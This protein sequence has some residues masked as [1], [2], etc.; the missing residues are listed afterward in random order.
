[1]KVILSESKVRRGVRIGTKVMWW[2][3]MSCILE[4]GGLVVS[5]FKLDI[6]NLGDGTLQSYESQ[7]VP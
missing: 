5:Y 4:R 1:M 7:C 2:N 6:C 3:R